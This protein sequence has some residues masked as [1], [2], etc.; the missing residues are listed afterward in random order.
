[1]SYTGNDI[2]CIQFIWWYS[3]FIMVSMMAYNVNVYSNNDTI[4]LK[5]L[6]FQH[7]IDFLQFTM[8]VPACN[9]CIQKYMCCNCHKYTDCGC[10]FVTNICGDVETSKYLQLMEISGVLFKFS[11]ASLL[12]S[13]RRCAIVCRQGG[14]VVVRGG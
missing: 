1:M 11:V 10:F 5:Y 2:S 8:C 4:F 14:G 9:K 13:W 6:I 7:T 3:Y 12:H